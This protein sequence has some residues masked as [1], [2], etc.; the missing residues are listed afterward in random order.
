[1]KHVFQGKI[2]E[3]VETRER[4]GRRRKQLLDDLKERRGYS[5][6]K[7]EAVDRDLWRNVH[8]VLIVPTGTLRLPLLRFFRAFS[9]VA[10]QM[11]GYNSQRWGTVRT[12]SN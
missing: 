9:S 4:R 12:L 3:M 7:E 5:K 8:S 10:R 2:D 11:P 1:M 6:L